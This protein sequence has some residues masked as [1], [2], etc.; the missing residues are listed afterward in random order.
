MG[1]AALPRGR[2][3]G[4]SDIHLYP[5]RPS[6][7]PA[8]A[9]LLSLP[10]PTWTLYFPTFE[11]GVRGPEVPYRCPGDRSWARKRAPPTALG[12]ASF[13]LGVV[14]WPL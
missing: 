2:S 5:S 1:V 12:G 8:P 10:R 14:S 13:S 9:L 11:S 7:T 6:P 4:T 3:L